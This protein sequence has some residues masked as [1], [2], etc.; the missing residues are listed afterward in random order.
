[1]AAKCNVKQESSGMTWNV[2]GYIFDK[3]KA[4][5]KRLLTG[6]DPKTKWGK[7]NSGRN[8]EGSTLDKAAILSIMDEGDTTAS[9][10]VFTD[11]SSKPQNSI[12]NKVLL[13]AM[14]NVSRATY[15]MTGR[16]YYI[17]LLGG[18][19][20]G[21]F[22]ERG[23]LWP[24]RQTQMAMKKYQTMHTESFAKILSKYDIAPR[25]ETAKNMT[26]MLEHYMVNDLTYPG[27]KENGPMLSELSKLYDTLLAEYNIYATKNGL[28]P[29]NTMTIGGAK[30]LLP[31]PTAGSTLLGSGTAGKSTAIR[32]NE[33]IEEMIRAIGN[34]DFDQETDLHLYFPQLI[35]T[36]GQGIFYNAAAKY[37]E[38]VIGEL[39][40][41]NTRRR[42]S[43]K[44]YESLDEAIGTLQNMV[45]EVYGGK[46]NEVDS[47]IKAL[48][49]DNSKADKALGV[50]QKVARSMRAATFAWNWAWSITK[51]TA[52]IIYIPTRFGAAATAI[53]A[54][55]YLF[56]PDFRKRV[57]S[58]YALSYKTSSGGRVADMGMGLRNERDPQ[59]M[60]RGFIAEKL[61]A[62]SWGSGKVAAYDKATAMGYLLSDTIETNLSILAAG[63][64][65]ASFE[66]AVA[67][68]SIDTTADM[69][70]IKDEWINNAIMR[71][72]SMYN[73]ED[74]VGL[75]GGR[76][77]PAFFP[78][79]SHTFELN[80]YI[81]EIMG[82]KIPIVRNVFLPNGHV[83]QYDSN[84]NPGRIVTAHRVVT[85]TKLFG[86]MAVA[87]MCIAGMDED[88]PWDAAN[89]VPFSSILFS[90]NSGRTGAMPVDYTKSLYGGVDRWM[91]FGDMK[92]IRDHMMKFHMMGG[93]QGKKMMDGVESIIN[94]EVRSRKGDHLFSIDKKDWPETI[95]RG[96]F[97]SPS[98]RQWKKR[99]GF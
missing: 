1:M 14:K 77:V 53:S 73:M 87:N 88:E 56:D 74:R 97:K 2:P 79:F 26:V 64:A 9:V 72:Q 35:D 5:Q 84:S 99:K 7:F 94:G 61:L 60:R 51:Q 23:L 28:S 32:N 81:G 33:G 75:L 38:K 55:R 15:R 44:E 95:A 46:L 57:Q 80:N 19:K 16:N 83:T 59:Y 52:S 21:N 63:A 6:V 78:F 27:V 68:G 24:L 10:R 20:F 43:S 96:P 48:V 12:L 54:R 50:T 47:G 98:A 8:I 4:L 66:K 34:S 71:T 40:T 3:I 58:S 29:I 37:S 65:E 86:L 67:N 93:I 90:G 85:L 39:E 18:G 49:G 91:E 30:G 82:N 11:E 17:A 45:D 76:N 13:E 22:L 92:G 62:T 41:E 70:R 31:M 89:F 42:E 69:D 36:I 25:S